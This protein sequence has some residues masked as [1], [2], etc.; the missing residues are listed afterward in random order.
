MSVLYHQMSFF[1]H[2]PRE[3]VEGDDAATRRRDQVQNAVLARQ[4]LA[5]TPWVVERRKRIRTLRRQ[6][7]WGGQDPED[8]NDKVGGKSL[9]PFSL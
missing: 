9:G 7:A 3:A 8:V 2:F 1:Y 5:P 4:H 6:L